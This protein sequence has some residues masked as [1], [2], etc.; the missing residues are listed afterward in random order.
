MLKRDDGHRE[1]DQVERGEQFEP[2]RYLIDGAHGEQQIRGARTFHCRTVDRLH[3][4]A[5]DELGLRRLLTN[6][7]AQAAAAA[8]LGFT[9]I[10]P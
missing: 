6:D 2:Q 9:V 5:M 8:A 3:L 10:T 7:K 1:K 4:A